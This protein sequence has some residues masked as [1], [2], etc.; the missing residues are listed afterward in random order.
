[1]ERAVSKVLSALAR[2]FRSRGLFLRE[3]SG[4]CSKA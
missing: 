2:T 1:M 4:A 3:E